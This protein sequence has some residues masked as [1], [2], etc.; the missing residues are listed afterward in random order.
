VDARI[1]T[2]SST[3]SHCLPP[4]V[5][6]PGTPKQVCLDVQSSV[7]SSGHRFLFPLHGG[8]GVWWISKLQLKMIY[9]FYLK[10]C[11]VWLME[12]KSKYLILV[13]LTDC[14]IYLLFW[15]PVF[16]FC[17]RL[18]LLHITDNDQFNDLFLRVVNQFHTLTFFRCS[19]TT[20]NI[21]TTDT[22]QRCT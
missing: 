5:F 18:R 8:T 4:L 11:I 13:L 14:I 3:F 6:L 20:N 9:N 17:F 16:L 10:F 1:I 19:S 12:W 21:N 2:S 22:L 15:V 7:S